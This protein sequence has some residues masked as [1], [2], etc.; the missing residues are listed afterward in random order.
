MLKRLLNSIFTLISIATLASCASVES[1]KSAKGTGTEKLY[2]ASCGDIF[3][4]VPSIADSTGGKIKEAN[5]SK[6][7]F[8]VEY[9]M[10][11]FSW[12]ERVAIF[13]DQRNGKAAVEVVSIRAYSQNITAKDWTSLIFEKLDKKFRR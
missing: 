7:Y 11:A 4:S 2:L 12:G 9:G 10:T 5:N 3:N 13:C 8:L 1:A 6:G